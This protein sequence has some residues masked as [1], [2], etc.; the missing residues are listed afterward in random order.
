MNIT[1]LTNRGSSYL[2]LVGSVLMVNLGEDSLL[3][4]ETPDAFLE[5]YARTIID[6]V[7]R[8]KTTTFDAAKSFIDFSS[9]DEI[10]E[11][12]RSGQSHVCELNP[13]FLAQ[14]F[15]HISSN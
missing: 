12:L 9:F 3:P 15:C 2:K 10:V 7:A 4:V 8:I 11:C 5:D 13:A 14:I 6:E 1:I